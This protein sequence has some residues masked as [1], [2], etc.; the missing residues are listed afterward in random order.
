MARI[1]PKMAPI[2]SQSV[3]YFLVWF[4]I[5]EIAK[6]RLHRFSPPKK[7]LINCCWIKCPIFSF[8]L[9][10]FFV[11]FFYFITFLAP[12]WGTFIF[13]YFYS[14]LHYFWGL[15]V[16]LMLSNS[17]VEFLGM[18]GVWLSVFAF[19]VYILRASFLPEKCLILFG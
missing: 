16:Y 3:Y 8:V 17:I 15:E 9:C 13:N 11:N 4:G 6:F 18:F 7:Q 5:T 19:L 1:F 12:I 10:L 14:T 2:I